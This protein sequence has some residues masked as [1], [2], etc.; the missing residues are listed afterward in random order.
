MVGGAAVALA[1]GLFGYQR[2]AIAQR[3]PPQ[4]RWDEMARRCVRAC[5]PDAYFDHRTGE[6]Q[7]RSRHFRRCP[8]GA[9]YSSVRHR[10]VRRLH[11]RPGF[12]YDA[13]RHACVRLARRC[14]PDHYYDF[15]RHRCAH[16]CPGGWRWTGSRCVAPGRR[17]RCAAGWSWNGYYHRCVRRV[18]AHCRPGWTWNG[19]RCVRW[20]RCPPNQYYSNRFHRCR[21]RIRNCPYGYRYR[22]GWGCQR[23]C[24]AGWHFA[25]GRCMRSTHRCPGSKFY[26]VALHRCVNRCRPGWYWD[27]K[28][29]RCLR[30][31]W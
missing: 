4:H 15:G 21:P 23:R 10:C 30:A 14:P 8:P 26:S 13:G 1:V 5:P 7:P 16:R 27:Y 29:R 28:R 2:S 12:A 24:A 25:G 19:F 31:S 9:Y 20:R 6:C 11:C 18:V 3:C 22:P 17:R